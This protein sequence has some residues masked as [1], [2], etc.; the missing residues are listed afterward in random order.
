MALGSPGLVVERGRATED[1]ERLAD[2]DGPLSELQV[3]VADRPRYSDGDVESTDFGEGGLES[4]LL[5]QFCNVKYAVRSPTPARLG[6]KLRSE[7][8]VLKGVENKPEN[9]SEYV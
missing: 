5:A 4:W 1:G 6:Q 2:G 8:F 7:L 9:R 3:G